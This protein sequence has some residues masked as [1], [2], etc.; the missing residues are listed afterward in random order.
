MNS[1]TFSDYG[2]QVADSASF[3]SQ[4]AT[5]CPQC[6]R[7]RKKKNAKCLSVNIDKG[8]WYCN[9]CGW[10]GGLGKN[11]QKHSPGWNKPSF[12]KPDPR[13]QLNL[14]QNAIDWFHSRGITD[15]VLLRNR[16]D[17]GS[18]YMPQTED[19]AETIIF[20][21]FRE[22]ELINRKYRQI[23]EKNF[24]LDTD[25]ER[26]LYGLDDMESESL[27]YVEGEMDKLA[28]EVAG[29]KSVVSVPNGAPSPDAKN[30]DSLF[31]FLEAPSDWKKIDSIGR[32][33]IAVDADAPGRKLETELARRLGIERCSRVRWPEGIKDANEM[34]L[35][36][37]A[38]ELKRCVD[39]AE[40]FPIKG[41]VEV[42]N[43]L[44]DVS[45]IY[46]MEMRRG[47]TTGWKAL[48]EFY[49]VRSGE[50]TTVTGIPSSGKSNWIDCLMVNMAKIHGW[51][52]AI[53][54]P[55]NLPVE[56]HVASLA[57]KYVLK[58]FN[59]GPTKRMELSEVESAMNWLG[60]FFFWIL[61]ND[62]AEWEIQNILKIAGQL[63]LRY[64]IRG[65]VI[66]PWNELESLRP[67]GM[68]ETE[69]ISQSLKRIRVF[70]RQRGVHV[71]VVIHPSKLY[72]DKEGEY[73]VPTLYDCSGSAHWRNKS[74]NG[75]VIW[76]DLSGD[77]TPEVE[78]HIQK[79]RFRQIGR[80]GMVALKYDPICATYWE[81]T[82]LPNGDW[83][84]DK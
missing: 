31:N 84:D 15:A 47:L 26:I 66:D 24:R 25:C 41:V 39:N 10:S 61:P 7:E 8:V 53:F 48:D 78:V 12:R 57:E 82:F 74:D 67:P 42:G 43:K 44:N 54:S 14:P 35:N 20:Q 45:A 32:H 64:G 6:S 70:A 30:Y 80:R 63:C 27:I 76:R 19:F 4:V 16:I 5:T 13:P 34:L 2:I 58:P 9:H 75:I 81:N 55:E 22:G 40:P 77:D 65:L 49:T 83:H 52:F 73:P 36:Y 60:K 1:K 72:R 23:S 51:R 46:N 37:G 56:Q 18:T 33:L 59:R 11:S 28:L 69:Y 3:G 79:I 71:W 62:E 29:F 38:E 50:F 21:Y 17:F 68:S